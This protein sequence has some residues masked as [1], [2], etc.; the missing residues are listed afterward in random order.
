MVIFFL[1]VYVR[2]HSS[3]IRTWPW[4][5]LLAWRARGR[6][7]WLASGGTRPRGGPGRHGAGQGPLGRWPS[8][9]A[10]CAREHASG[11]ARGRGAIRRRR[12]EPGRGVGP[13]R[14]AAHGAGCR[15]GMAGELEEEGQPWTSSPENRPEKGKQRGNSQTMMDS[16]KEW[17]D[18]VEDDELYLVV[19]LVDAGTRWFGRKSS[20]KSSSET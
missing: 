4:K 16:R 13:C 15:R 8:A 14:V 9:T 11:G 12:A 19:V 1:S 20:P 18:G 17:Q 10:S 6:P 3:C 2:G 7:A 5:L